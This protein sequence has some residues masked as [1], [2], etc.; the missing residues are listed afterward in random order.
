VP[1]ADVRAVGV[2]LPI[3]QRV[4]LAVVGH[5]LDHRSL[6]RSRAERGEQC[7]KRAAGLEAAVAQQSMEA[8]RHPE[9]DRH[10]GERERDQV[11]PAK[12]A[13]PGL[14]SRKPDE[15][16]RDDGYRDVGDPVGRAADLRQTAPGDLDRG[17]AAAVG[18]SGVSVG[19]QVVPV[20]ESER[21]IRRA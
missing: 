17:C 10:V 20:A 4:V 1:V 5:P 8:D 7:P 15:Q 2:A 14:P 12:G 9:A 3:G 13:V 16:E 19:G 11:G 18:E 6:D 21:P